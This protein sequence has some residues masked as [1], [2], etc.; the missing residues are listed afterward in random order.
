[1]ADPQD[2]SNDP[3]SDSSSGSDPSDPRDIKPDAFWENMGLD[4]NQPLAA[5]TCFTGIL[6]KSAKEGYWTLY[7][8]LDMSEHLEISDGDIVSSQ[9]LPADQSPFGSLG[10]TRVCV[11]KGATIR[12]VR[13]TSRHFQAGSSSTSEFD[14]D[15]RLGQA[16]GPAAMAPQLLP[17]SDWNTQCAPECGFG[18]TGIDQT[19]LT[20]RSCGDTCFRTCNDTCITQCD[21]C[22]GDTCRTCD[23]CLTRCAQNTCQTCQTRC[24]QNTCATCQTQCNQNTCATCQTQC[25]TCQTCQTQ[26]A[27]A[28]CATCQTRCG[29]ATCLTCQTRCATCRTCDEFCV[30]QLQTHCFTCAPGCRP[31]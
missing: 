3:Q 11:K 7:L 14:L 30:T 4:P 15:V 9:P 25:G 12:H 5:V 23:T 27:Q 26:C 16:R 2:A 24:G 17:A 19:C 18:G 22:P 6:G 1:M 13:T 20:C 28:T 31:F 10:G 8:R 29:Q 21:T